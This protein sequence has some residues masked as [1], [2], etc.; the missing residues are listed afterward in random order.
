[1]PGSALSRFLKKLRLRSNSE[2]QRHFKKSPKKFA[3]SCFTIL[4]NPNELKLPRL[5]VSLSKKNIPNAVDRNR[6]KRIVRESFRLRQHILPAVDIVIIGRQ[7]VDKKTNTAIH[8][9]LEK[10][11]DEII[12]YYDEKK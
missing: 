1:M 9:I 2:F 7:G 3:S 5:G 6:V 8:T 12:R 4:I 10:Q 11:W